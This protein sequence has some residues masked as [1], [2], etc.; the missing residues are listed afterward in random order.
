MK[1]MVVQMA[2]FGKGILNRP[3][4]PLPALMGLDR[5]SGGIRKKDK[6]FFAS[7]L[8]AQ[9]LAMLNHTVDGSSL[10]VAV[11]GERGSGKTTL[12]NRFTAGTA[13]CWQ[14][15]RIRLRPHK[16]TDPDLWRNLNN[17]L[18]F[19][20]KKNSLPTVIIDDAHQLSPGELKLLLELTCPQHGK[21]RFH[22]LV[23]FAGPQMRGRFAEIARRLPPKATI[24]K[25]FMSPLTEKQTE[26][27]LAH[28]FR[29][30]GVLKKIPFSKSQIKEIFKESGGLPGWING[31][32]FMRLKKI[33][34][35]KSHFKQPFLPWLLANMEW[36]QSAHLKNS[37]CPAH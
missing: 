21:R 29:A 4:V 36:R 33:Y 19:I 22:S 2:T 13:N 20:S 25:I 15:C 7:P 11:I 16:N 26:E 18:V 9:R 8:I 35:G 27:Y 10:V 28:R 3:T 17:R 37:G 6:F 32:A 34:H 12:M 5:P 14:E 1:A 24:D 31:S 23:L 30:A